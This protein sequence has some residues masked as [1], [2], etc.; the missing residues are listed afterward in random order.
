MKGGSY[1]YVQ[2]FW[3]F[4]LTMSGRIDQLPHV[5]VSGTAAAAQGWAL[6]S[7]R[8]RQSKAAANPLPEKRG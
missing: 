5:P 2:Q 7:G 4:G 1:K 8:G 6:D 3:R